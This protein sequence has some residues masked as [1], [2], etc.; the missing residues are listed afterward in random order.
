MLWISTVYCVRPYFVQLFEQPSDIGH[1]CHFSDEKTEAWEG[2][3][4]RAQAPWSSDLSHSTPHTH[5]GALSR[6]ACAVSTSLFV[7]YLFSPSSQPFPQS[8]IGQGP[9]R[10][11]HVSLGGLVHPKTI[12]P[13]QGLELPSGKPP[14]RGPTTSPAQC[15]QP[16]SAGTATS[17]G[18]SSCVLQQPGTLSSTQGH[19]GRGSCDFWCA[20]S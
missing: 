11:Y 1:Y 12:S 5:P 20:D 10:T 18:R 8:V 2:E 15:E 3:H 6:W 19:S 13:W 17:E 4:C 14:T 16:A 9:T 7:L